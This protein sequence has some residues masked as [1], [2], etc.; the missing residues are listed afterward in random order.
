[1]LMIKLLYWLVIFY[2]GVRLSCSDHSSNEKV[3]FKEAGH[4]G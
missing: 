3:A 4:C 1:M 2:R